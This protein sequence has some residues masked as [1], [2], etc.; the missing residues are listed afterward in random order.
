ML[1]KQ[2]LGEVDAVES[3]ECVLLVL[4]EEASIPKFMEFVSEVDNKLLDVGLL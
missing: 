3:L 1:L 2:L 4:G